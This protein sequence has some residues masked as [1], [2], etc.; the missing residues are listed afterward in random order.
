MRKS[1]GSQGDAKKIASEKR[2]VFLREKKTLY[3]FKIDI[4]SL[5]TSRR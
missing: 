2:Q 1:L 5:S 3:N 4:T